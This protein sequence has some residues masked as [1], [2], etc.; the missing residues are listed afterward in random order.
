MG[1]YSEEQLN[2]AVNMYQ[3]KA[4]L[5]MTL[6]SILKDTGVDANTLYKEIEN[7]GMELMGFNPRPTIDGMEDAIELVKNKQE[8]KLTQREIC[9]KTGVPVHRL[10][11]E[12]K[13]RDIIMDTSRVID[14]TGLEEAITLYRNKSENR[15]RVTEIVKKT[16]VCRTLLYQELRKLKLVGTCNKK[17][18][19][20]EKLEEAIDLYI[21]RHKHSVRVNDIRDL[22][23]VHQGALYSELKRRKIIE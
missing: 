11:E 8:N 22:T 1:N 17:N 7:R 15:L 10:R 12:L 14:T 6:R 20:P 9:K 18:F 19:T 4:T 2:K 5:R 23:G 3:N 21:N 13:L 16:G